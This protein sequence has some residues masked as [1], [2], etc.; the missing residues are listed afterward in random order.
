[1]AARS[2][3][4]TRRRR[5]LRLSFVE[6]SF[7]GV[8]DEGRGVEIGLTGAKADNVDAG[9]LHRVGLGAHGERDGIGDYFDS[10]GKANHFGPPGNRAGDVISAARRFQVPKEG[11]TAK[12]AKFAE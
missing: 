4:R 10:V 3:G 7:G 11:L 5:V 2:S 9:F 1:M 12:G 8:L 6:R